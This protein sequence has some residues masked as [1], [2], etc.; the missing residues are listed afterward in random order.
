MSIP[1]LPFESV[2]G[3]NSQINV[4]HNYA[5]CIP[6]TVTV[7]GLPATNEAVNHHNFAIIESK[8][9]EI[10]SKDEIIALLKEQVE[11]WKKKYKKLKKTL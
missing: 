8:D 7:N 4:F 11:Y 10:K 5:P 1:P 2:T 3:H 9:R 6:P